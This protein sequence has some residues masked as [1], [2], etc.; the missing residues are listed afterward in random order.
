MFPGHA[1]MFTT[2]GRERGFPP[3]T[4]ASFDAMCGPDGAYL[5]G[6]PTTVATKVQTISE[7][8]GGVTRIS[9]QMTNV[10]L[11]HHSLLRSVELLGTEVA[12]LVHAATD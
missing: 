4:R 10:R 7:A 9:L 5:V 11:A 12:P 6:D 1:E 2:I 3:P 8:L